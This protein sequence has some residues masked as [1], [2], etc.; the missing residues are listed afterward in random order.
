M[1]LSEYQGYSN[2]D[3][4]R[5]V[6]T[7]I[8][9]HIADVEEAMLRDHKMGA[10][11]Q[12]SG[13]VLL[14]QEGRGFDWDVQ[15]RNHEIEGNTGQTARN[16]APRNLWKKAYLEY[17]GYQVTDA[18]YEKE[19]LEN[20]GRAAQIKV[21]DKLI[22][23]LKTSM[24][25][26]LAGQYWIDG[27]ATGNEQSWHGTESFF[28]A[29]QTINISTGAARTANAA[30]WVAYPNDTYAGLSTVLGNYDG[31]QNTGAVWPLGTADPEFDFY[32]PIIVNYTSSAFSGSADTWA[33]QGDEAMRFGLTHSGRNKMRY[34][35]THYFL[36]R[37]L[38][39]LF[40]QLIDDK[41]RI[42]V[43]RG[44]GLDLVSL[45]FR[46]VVNFDGVQVTSENTIPAAVGYGINMRNI[47][48]RC[49][50]D[51]FLTSEGPEYDIDTQ[52]WKVVVGTLSNLR[53]KSPRNFVKM[54]TLA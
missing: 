38:Y 43:E 25:E 32:S 44:D 28:G 19:R 48:L 45:G 13:R 26:G 21:W 40:K 35:L 54:V 17:R 46:D 41:E 42:L 11:L 23:R 27:N 3:W 53:F 39:R 15:Y 9:N 30:D 4:A 12:A 8:A 7:T 6:Q 18:M 47:D 29:T 1:A 14:N 51:K 24:K 52:A 16:F 2:T 31:E 36:D 34:D 5:T 37:E 49:M 10:M 50:T 22:D 20:R 33:A